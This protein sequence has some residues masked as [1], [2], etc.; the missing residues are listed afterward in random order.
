MGLEGIQFYSSDYR[1]KMCYTLCINLTTTKQQEIFGYIQGWLSEKQYLI[2]MT[3][4]VDHIITI[5]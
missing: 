5:L 4:T 1:L 3:K 2:F